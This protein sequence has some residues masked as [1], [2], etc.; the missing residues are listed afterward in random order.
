MSNVDI[1]RGINSY[2]KLQLLQYK[3][4]EKFAVFRSWG[5][6]GSERIGGKKLDKFRDL[7]DAIENFTEV[8]L[9]KTG[10]SF[11]NDDPIKKP[12]KFFPLDINYDVEE[13]C[14]GSQESSEKK[15]KENQKINETELAKQLENSKKIK[16]NLKPEVVDLM[17]M[18]F[19]IQ[20]FK[21]ELKSTS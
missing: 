19:D 18:I 7:Q 6:V 8:Y 4:K 9:D 1:E 14:D 20:K 17:T 10:N 12:R 3:T 5:R 11:Y 15:K 13:E 2:Y 21:K 16:S